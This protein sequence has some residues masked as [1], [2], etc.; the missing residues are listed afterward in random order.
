MKT[1]ALMS[2]L[3]ITLI[4][5]CGGGGAPSDN[6][7]NIA[8]TWECIGGCSG[9]CPFDNTITITQDGSDFTVYLSNGIMQGS[10]DNDGNYDFPG[11]NET[12]EGNI[13]T[14]HTGGVA[15]MV[16]TGI[17]HIAEYICQTVTY[18]K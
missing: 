8:G 15:Y 17:C 10:I 18:K 6:P 3:V 12:C 13:T 16:S 4:A 14:V 1:I 5:A 11:A 7:P 9:V 2:L